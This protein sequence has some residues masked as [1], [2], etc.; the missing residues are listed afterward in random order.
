MCR[1]PIAVSSATSRVGLS[2]CTRV[3]HLPHGCGTTPRDTVG[4]L[5]THNVGDAAEDGSVAIPLMQ[6]PHG[7]MVQRGREGFRKGMPE[8]R[9]WS[10]TAFLSITLGQRWSSY[11]SR[12]SLPGTGSQVVQPVEIWLKKPPGILGQMPSP[13]ARLLERPLPNGFLRD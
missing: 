8:E 12:K 4:E 10:A 9:R 6:S 2:R 1:P 13:R 7:H 5:G 11:G 3:S